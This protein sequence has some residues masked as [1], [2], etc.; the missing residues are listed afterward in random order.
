MYTEEEDLISLGK[1]Y[2]IFYLCDNVSHLTLKL[3]SV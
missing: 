2:V 1:I 3:D